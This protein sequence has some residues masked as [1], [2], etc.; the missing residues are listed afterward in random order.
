MKLRKDYR[1]VSRQGD[2]WS[3]GG[4]RS[5]FSSAPAKVWP[6]QCEFAAVSHTA[7]RILLLTAAFLAYTA[8]RAA[9]HRS[10]QYR[11]IPFLFAAHLA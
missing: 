4:K 11:C 5:F 3:M 6:G 9:D 2:Q 1:V 8:S 10:R 7:S